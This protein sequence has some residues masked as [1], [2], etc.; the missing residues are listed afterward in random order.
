MSDDKKKK[1]I[2]AT[3]LTEP[4]GGLMEFQSDSFASVEGFWNI[5]KDGDDTPY[6]GEYVHGVLLNEVR[7]KAGKPLDNPFFVMELITP[8]KRIVVKDENKNESEAEMAA[9]KRIGF[10]STWKSLS[11]LQRKAGHEVWIRYDGKKKL[12]NGRVAKSLTVRVSPKAV[13]EVEQVEE[14][15][16]NEGDGKDA[17]LPEGL[18]G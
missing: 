3:T 15:V 17:D 1:G 4:P 10:S 6:V 13:R 8:H 5:P 11:G 14:K 12:P 7:T 2:A 16:W 9:G 18:R